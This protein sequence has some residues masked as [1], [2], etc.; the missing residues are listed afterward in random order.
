VRHGH[1]HEDGPDEHRRT[2]GC[3]RRRPVLQNQPVLGLPAGFLRPRVI[4][5]LSCDPDILARDL[6]ALA[7]RRYAV[8]SVTPFDMLPHRPHVEVLAILDR[9]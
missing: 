9:T 5:Y 6:A 8:R 2:L 4:G 3:P 1:N 7:E